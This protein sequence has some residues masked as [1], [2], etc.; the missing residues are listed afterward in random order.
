[1]KGLGQRIHSL[2]KERKLTL[3]EIAK[4]TGIDQA[5]LS[6]I[7][8]GRMT[9]TLESH[10]KLAD[11]LG[12]RLPE[13]YDQV[14]TQIHEAREKPIRRRIEAFSHS[15]GAVSELLT[16]GILQKRMMPVLL[17]LKPRGHTEPEEYRAGTER[18]VY[19][20]KGAVEVQVEQQKTLLRQ[21]ESLYLDASEPH[22]FRN[23]AKKG[24]SWCLAVLTP[25]AL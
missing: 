9:G 23:A 10:M 25:T 13:L 18:F 14:I 8:N 7:E 19:V 12:I 21:T 17:K 11:A 16:T 24:E 22:H 1:M 5:T 15:S 4:R 3:V 2:R 20:L 6:R